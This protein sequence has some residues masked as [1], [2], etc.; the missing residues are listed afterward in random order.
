[1]GRRWAGAHSRLELSAYD[2]LIENNRRRMA[3]LEYAVRQLDREWF[4][5]LRFP[6]HEDSCIA[7]GV[8]VG[9]E[10]GALG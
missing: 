2:E 6:D 10:R 5:R 3:V 1:M 4:V 7:D 8:P 9:W